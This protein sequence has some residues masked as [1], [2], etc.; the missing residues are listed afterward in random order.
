MSL[1]ISSTAPVP[2]HVIGLGCDEVEAQPVGRHQRALLRDVI[3]E[4]LAQRFVQQMRRGVIGA[5]RRR[6]AA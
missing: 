3:A 2:P 1:A 5:D 4:H 6:G